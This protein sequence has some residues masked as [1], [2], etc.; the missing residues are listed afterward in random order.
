VTIHPGLASGRWFDLSL[1][2]QLG[3]IGSEVGRALTAKRNGNIIRF[4]AAFMRALDL[5]DLSLADRRWEFP[6]LREIARARETT[7]DFLSG[8]NQYDSTVESIERYFTSFAV[9]ARI[10]HQATA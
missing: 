5:F 10:H 1:V 2:E 4:D 7:V 6:Q 8:A 3:N 9:A